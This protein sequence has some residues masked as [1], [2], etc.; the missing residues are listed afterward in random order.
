[1]SKGGR[2]AEKCAIDGPF[3]VLRAC[4]PDPP[5]AA[6]RLDIRML[7]HRL[8]AMQIASYDCVASTSPRHVCAAPARR[9]K[10]GIHAQFLY[11]RS[12]QRRWPSS[13]SYRAQSGAPRS[14]RRLKPF[15]GK[16]HVRS[17]GGPVLV[18]VSQLG[19]LPVVAASRA[20]QADD[21]VADFRLWILLLI[22]WL[23]I[24]FFFFAMGLQK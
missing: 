12:R 18:L 1:M 4:F 10:A 8:A 3:L 2:I 21:E 11:G 9:N 20:L 6:A 14:H 15:L 7:P 22:T 5:A 16:V 17:F 13:A 24:L 19:V 23:L